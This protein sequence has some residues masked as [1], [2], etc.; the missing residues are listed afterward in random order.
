VLVLVLVDCR[1]QFSEAMGE[2][3]DCR[4]SSSKQLRQEA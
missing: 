2:E 3:K 1:R 4:R